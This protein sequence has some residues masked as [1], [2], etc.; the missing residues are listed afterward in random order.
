M[1]TAALIGLAVLISLPSLAT[2][3]ER[4]AI[5]EACKADAQAN[6]SV[7]MSR[8]KTIACLA[9]NAAKVSDGCASALK[10]ASCNAKAPDVLKAAFPCAQ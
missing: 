9:D 7:L 3:D 1:K 4:A 5:R 10:V 8:S 6:C 2:A